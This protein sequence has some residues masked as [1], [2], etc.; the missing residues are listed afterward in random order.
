MRGAWQ[1]YSGSD[2]GFLDYGGLVLPNLNLVMHIYC[3]YLNELNHEL[4]DFITFF[5][6]KC[7]N[8][9]QQWK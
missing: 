9:S 8:P 1:V 2:S 3:V 7:I 6:G 4:V 5:K